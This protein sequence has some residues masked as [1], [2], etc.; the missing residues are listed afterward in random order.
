MW[1]SNA[2]SQSQ[3]RQ[4]WVAAVA[5]SFLAAALVVIS[6]ESGADFAQ[7]YAAA[8]AWWHGID[9]SAPTFLIYQACCP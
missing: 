9:P 4:Q 6:Q 2:A 3:N 8:W 7:D 5:G 1:A